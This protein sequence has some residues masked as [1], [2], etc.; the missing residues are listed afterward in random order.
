MLEGATD[1]FPDVRLR[2][3]L[4]ETAAL[5]THEQTVAHSSIKT[6]SDK[7]FGLTVGGILAAIAWCAGGGSARCPGS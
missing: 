7:S 2:N 5:S 1:E 3:P 6:A 4:K